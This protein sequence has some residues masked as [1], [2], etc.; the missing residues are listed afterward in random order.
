M[1]DSEKNTITKDYFRFEKVD[2]FFHDTLS[3][4]TIKKMDSYSW[5]KANMILSLHLIS[6]DNSK[7]TMLIQP[8]TG[9]TFRVRFHPEKTSSNDYPTANTRTVVLDSYQELLEKNK[10]SEFYIEVKESI[11]TGKIVELLFHGSLETQWTKIQIMYEPF[12]IN[13]IK[14]VHEPSNPMSWFEYTICSTPVNGLKYMYSG[15]FDDYKIIQTITKPYTAKYV[16]FGE[17]GGIDLVKNN[18]RITYFNY[19]NMRYR[20]VYNR[21]PFEE[22]EPLYHSDP[23]FIEVN[24]ILDQQSAYGIFIDNPSEVVL[25]MGYYNSTQYAFGTRYG[26]MDF[27]VL[28]GNTCSDIIKSFSNIIGTARLIPRYAL[29]YHQGCYGYESR[30]DV[31]EVAKNHRKYQIPLDGIHIDV[32]LQNN[33]KTFTIDECKFP[34]PKDMFSSLKEMGIKCSTNI[35]PIISNRNTEQYSTYQEAMQHN[36]FILDER[37]DAENPD[38]T[39]YYKY[40]SGKEYEYPFEDKEHNYNSKKPFIGEVYYGNKGSVELGTTGHYPDLNRKEVRK[41]WGQQYQYLFDMGLEMVWQDMT[42]PCLRD[43]RGDMLSFPSRLLVNNDFIKQRDK[44]DSYEKV[45][46]MK[47]WNLYSYN[48]HKATYHGLNHLSGRENK[49]N[50]I[51]GRGCFTGMQRFAG[52]WTGDNSSSWEFLKINISQ[53]LALGLTGQALSGQDIGGFEREQDWEQWADPELLIRWTAL[54]AFLPWFRNHYIRKGKKLFQEPY[55]YQFHANEVE[56]NVK[57]IYE[58]TLPICKY[59]IELRYT[60][61]QLFYDAMFENTLN[62]LPICRAL[63]LTNPSD[64]AL[65]NDKSSFLNTEFMVRNELLIAPIIEKECYEN[66]FGKRDVYLPSGNNWYQFMNHKRPLEGAIQGGTT[67]SEFDCSINSETHHIPYIVPI[68]VKE[69]AIIPTIELEQYVGERNQNGLPNPIT[70]HIYPGL[71]GNYTMYLD[72]GISRS[73]QPKGDT[74]YGSDPAANGEYREVSITH[75]YQ[76]L[77]RRQVCIKRIHDGYTPKY[78]TYFFVSILHTPS[79]EYNPMQSIQLNNEYIP[80]LEHGTME[81]LKASDGNAWYYD[82]TTHTSYIKIFDTAS[83]LSMDIL[84]KGGTDQYFE[85]GDGSKEHPYEI[86]TIEQLNNLS[87]L[88][89]TQPDLY[90]HCYYKVTADI[91]TDSYFH[92]IGTMESPFIGTLDGGS[93]TITLSLNSDENYLGL[94]GVVG[95][96]ESSDGQIVHLKLD[97]KI[98][99]TGSMIGAV[100]GCLQNGTIEDVFLLGTTIIKGKDNIGGIV[101]TVTNGTIKNCTSYATIQGNNNVGGIAGYNSHIIELCSNAGAIKGNTWIGG[102]AGSSYRNPYSYDIA[103]IKNCCNVGNIKATS[104]LPNCFGGIVGQNSYAESMNNCT[105]TTY[106]AFGQNS[107]P[108]YYTYYFAA[109]QCAPDAEAKDANEFESGEVTELL[110]KNTDCWAQ[111]SMEDITV[112]HLKTYPIL[113]QDKKNNTTSLT[114]KDNSKK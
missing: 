62:G 66:G 21:G 19:D 110:N 11:T 13:V 92:P 71:K 113:K 103:Y 3:W 70:L 77:H 14:E 44:N 63:F 6:D 49:R 98:L 47:I 5:D 79:E 97:G 83:S 60:L 24:G 2:E 23:F 84:Y 20:Q 38:G 9:S 39:V 8:A 80:H 57:Y 74:H 91:T 54:G 1:S 95:N 81:H 102:I 48:L 61:L 86:A 31:E 32:D 40:A 87:N 69:G 94:F 16:G 26:D 25:D 30:H 68:Y 99:S 65:F 45:P 42:T 27:Y 7:S 56:P 105:A 101:G 85:S 18:T 22:R 114:Q 59:Y 15:G 112:E 50:F 111:G 34:N 107:G 64:M 37:F 104:M 78:E 75:S 12:Y 28:T 29:G 96:T 106:R 93:H 55:E 52:L 35:T 41:W 46:V 43:T 109:Y 82:S 53:V 51:I 4:H 33:Y 36:Y 108:I 89:Q 100:A 72:D 17:Q 88:T 73:S 67:I 10:T 90:A 76:S 58:S